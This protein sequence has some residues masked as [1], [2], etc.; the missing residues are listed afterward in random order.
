MAKHETCLLFNSTNEM[1]KVSNSIDYYINNFGGIS[2]VLGEVKFEVWYNKQLDSGKTAN[3]INET[4]KN[5]SADETNELIYNIFN[6]S[7]KVITEKNFTVT[8]EELKTNNVLVK[9]MFNNNNFAVKYDKNIKT[10]NDLIKHCLNEYLKNYLNNVNF[11]YD[12]KG[13]ATYANN[14]VS[15]SKSLKN[16]VQDLTDAYNLYKTTVNSYRDEQVNLQQLSVD[17][18]QDFINELLSNSDFRQFVRDI[19]AQIQ[20]PKQNSIWQKIL[21]AIKNFFSINNKQPYTI[22]HKAIHAVNILLNDINVK[23]IDDI[24]NDKKTTTISDIND[25]FTNVISVK[26]NTKLNADNTLTLTNSNYNLYQGQIVKIKVAENNIALSNIW[27]IS[28]I[29]NDVATLENINPENIKLYNFETQHKINNV[30]SSEIQNENNNQNNTLN[31]LDESIR[32]GVW[33]DEQ[34]TERAYNYTVKNLDKLVDDYISNAGNTIDPDAIREVYKP[35]GYTG[36]NVPAFRKAEKLLTETIFEK[37]IDKAVAEGKTSMTFLTGVPGSGKSSSLRNNNMDLSDQG[38]V[39][40]AAFNGSDKLIKYIKKV[41]DRGLKNVTVLAVHNDAITSFTNTLNR[42]IATGRFLSL[43]YFLDGAFG[44]NLNKIQDI[45]DQCSDINIIPI[46]NSGNNGGKQVTIEEA[47]N[48]DYNVTEELVYKLLNIIED[49]I[50]KGNISGEQI[51]SVGR[52]VLEIK[53]L[54]SERVQRIAKRIENKIKSNERDNQ[55][56]TGLSGLGVNSQQSAITKNILNQILDHLKKGA[57]VHFSAEM[58]EYL[59]KHNLEDLQKAIQYNEEITAIKDAAIKNGTFMKAPNGE[60]TNLNERQWLQVRTK[61]FK[62]WFGDWENDPQN[63][64][65]IVDENGE[66]KVMWHTAKRGKF[67]GKQIFRKGTNGGKSGNGIYF[68]FSR[69]KTFANIKG[70]YTYQVFLNMRNPLTR[71]FIKDHNLDDMYVQIG[72]HIIELN[73]LEKL[74]NEYGFDGTFAVGALDEV[75][76]FEPNQIKSAT[77]NN[78]NFS[79]TDDDIRAAWGRP[80]VNN[81]MSDEEKENICTLLKTIN[82]TGTTLLDNG[83]GTIINQVNDLSFFTT[84]QGEIYGFVTKDGEIYLDETVISPEHPIHEY[85]HLW[86]RMVQQQN[87]ELWKRGVELMK[88]TSMWTDIANDIHY[89]KLWE[90]QG[91]TGTELEDRIASEVHAR[92]TGEGGA[93]LLDQIAKE[94]GSEGIIAK[95]KDWIKE[96]WSTLKATFSN[97]SKKDLDKLTLKDFN[98]MTVRDFADG[99]NFENLSQQSQQSQSTSVLSNLIQPKKGV[100]LKKATAKASIANKFIGFGAP[101]SSTALY[102]QQAGEYAN[103]GDYTKDDT[104]FVSINGKVKNAIEYQLQTI[105]EAV[106]AIRSGARLL[107]DSAEYL[108][109]SSYNT[110]EK[111]LAEHLKLIGATYQTIDIDGEKVG[112]WTFSAKMQATNITIAQLADAIG[113]ENVVTDRT[114][115]TAELKNIRKTQQYANEYNVKEEHLQE[116]LDIKNAAIQNGTFMKAPNGKPSNLDERKWL[117]VRTKTFKEWFGD[118]ENDPQNASKV[119]DENG[120]PK[121]VYH[122]TNNIFYIFD[123]NKLGSNTGALS[124]KLGFFT[125]DDIDNSDRYRYNPKIPKSVIE[126]L[127]KQEMIKTIINETESGKKFYEE[128]EL[129]KNNYIQKVTEMFNSF[130]KRYPTKPGHRYDWEDYTTTFEII[131]PNLQIST[132]IL[133]PL[134]K[135]YI[136][137]LDGFFKFHDLSKLDES[138]IKESKD[139]INFIKNNLEKIKLFSEKFKNLTFTTEEQ[140]VIQDAMQSEQLMHEKKGTLMHLFLN[141][142]DPKIDDDHGHMYREES[143]SSRMLKAISQNKDGGIIKNTHD[144]LAT[145]VYYFFDPNQAKSATDNNGDFSNT[146]DDIRYHKNNNDENKTLDIIKFFK[147]SKGDIFGFVGK[148]NKIYLDITMIDSNTAIHE[149]THLWVDALKRTNSKEWDHV[150]NLMRNIKSESGKVLWDYVKKQY[151]ELKT[152]SEIAEEVLAHYSGEQGAIK[153]EKFIEKMPCTVNEKQTFFKKLKE[154]L[155]SFWK[156][157]AKMLGDIHY[158]TAQHVA[159][160]VLYDFANKINPNEI[161]KTKEEEMQKQQ[162]KQA[163]NNQSVQQNIQNIQSQSTANTT[164]QPQQPQQQEEHHYEFEMNIDDLIGNDDKQQPATTTIAN[165]DPVRQIPITISARDR[166]HETM[167][168]EQIA[169]RTRFLANVFDHVVHNLLHNDYSDAAEHFGITE[170]EANHLSDMDM[171]RKI[172]V[173]EIFNY[174]KDLMIKWKDKKIEKDPKITNKVWFNQLINILDDVNFETLKNKAL[175]TSL[176]ANQS[177]LNKYRNGKDKIVDA[178]TTTE[179]EI[180]E[181][182]VN[183]VERDND[184]QNLIDD[185]YN[186]D[187]EIVNVLQSDFEWVKSVG[188]DGLFKKANNQVKLLLRGIRIKYFVDGKSVPKKNDFGFSDYMDVKTMF[189][190]IQRLNQTAISPKQLLSRIKEKSEVNPTFEDLYDRLKPIPIKGLSGQEYKSAIKENNRKLFLLKQLYSATNNVYLKNVDVRDYLIDTDEGVIKSDSGYPTS[191]FTLNMVDDGQALLDAWKADLSDKEK[192]KKIIDFAHDE[193]VINVNGEKI[194]VG[195]NYYLKK[196]RDIYKKYIKKTGIQYIDKNGYRRDKLNQDRISILKEEIETLKEILDVLDLKLIENNCETT[197]DIWE[198]LERHDLQYLETIEPDEIGST[199]TSELS[200]CLLLDCLNDG[201]NEYDGYDYITKGFWSTKSGVKHPVYLEW[202]KFANLFG[203]LYTQEVEKSFFYNGKTFMSDIP[204]SRISDILKI[205]QCGDEEYIN[206]WINENYKRVKWYGYDPKTNT[207][208]NEFLT[209]VLINREI[210][211]IC[212]QRF[213]S[214]A[215]ETRVLGEVLYEKGEYEIKEVDKFTKQDF[216]ESFAAMYKLGYS[217]LPPLADSGNLLYIKTRANTSSG[218]YNNE[219]LYRL[220]TDLAEQEIDRIAEVYRREKEVISKNPYA[221][222]KNYDIVRNSDGT[223]K[224]Y[225]GAKFVFLEALNDCRVFATNDEDLGTIVTDGEKVDISVLSKKG[226]TQDDFK[227]LS[228]VYTSTKHHNG[229]LYYRIGNQYIY[230]SNQRRMLE[231]I[232]EDVMNRYADMYVSKIQIGENYGIRDDDGHDLYQICKD[233]RKRGYEISWEKEY[234]KDAI[235]YIKNYYLNQFYNFVSITQLTVGDLAY[236]KEMQG[237][238]MLDFAK[239]FKGVFGRTTRLAAEPNEKLRFIILKDEEFSSE[240]Y[241][242]ISTWCDELVKQGTFK[243][244]DAKTIKGSLLNITNTDGQGLISPAAL[245]DVYES[246][247]NV[248]YTIIEALRILQYD[249]F[250]HEQE[251]KIEEVES[252]TKKDVDAAK[253]V[254]LENISLFCNPIKPFLQT[255]YIKPDETGYNKESIPLQV[256]NSEFLI[257]PLTVVGGLF[258]KSPK[259]KALYRIMGDANIDRIQFESAIKVGSTGVIDVSQL[260]DENEIYDTIINAINNDMFDKEDRLK[261]YQHNKEQG[262]N[263]RI[264]DKGNVVKSIPKM[265]FG[266]QVDT[267]QNDEETTYGS[268]LKGIAMSN[269]DSSQTYTIKIGNKNLELNGDEIREIFIALNKRLNKLGYDQLTKRYGIK[270]ND[271]GDYILNDKK[272]NDAIIKDMANGVFDETNLVDGFVLNDKN[273]PVVPYNE[274]NV[275]FSIYKTLASCIKNYIFKQKVK[276]KTLIQ[277]SNFGVSKDLHCQFGI[278]VNDKK[279][280]INDNW[281]Q[282]NKRKNTELSQELGLDKYDTYLDWANVMW[283][284][285]KIYLDYID[286]YTPPFD[287]KMREA[288]TEEVKDKNGK[289]IGTHVNINKKTT[290]QVKDKNGNITTKEVPILDPRLRNFI[291]YRIPSEANCSIF[292]CRVKDFLPSLFGETVM[293]PAEFIAITGSDFDIDKI[294]TIMH[295]H[296]TTKDGRL[297]KV[298]DKSLNNVNSKDDLLN[299]ISNMNKQNIN[300]MLIDTMTAIFANPNTLQKTLFP[301]SYQTLKHRFYTLN[302]INNAKEDFE[303]IQEKYGIDFTNINDVTN[304]DIK[305]LEKINDKY[306]KKFDAC[307]LETMLDIQDNNMCGKQN[308]GIYAVGSKLHNVLMSINTKIERLGTIQ[309]A[310]HENDE[311]YNTTTFKHMYDREGRLITNNIKEFQASSVDNGKDPILYML[312]QNPTTAGMTNIMLLAG[313]TIDDIVFFFNQP[314][315]IELTKTI[316]NNLTP[317]KSFIGLNHVVLGIT[318]VVKNNTDNQ[319]SVDYVVNNIITDNS[320]STLYTDKMY[321]SVLQDKN[322][323]EERFVLF[324]TF[325]NI[326]KITDE[327]RKISPYI[328]SDNTKSALPTNIVKTVKYLVQMDHIRDNEIEIEGF[329]AGNIAD[330][331]DNSSAGFIQSYLQDGIKT[332]FESLIKTLQP[333]IYELYLCLKQLTLGTDPGLT[334]LSAIK[335][336]QKEIIKYEYRNYNWFRHN[337]DITNGTF[338]L[339]FSK[340]KKSPDYK[341]YFEKNSFLR[342]LSVNKNNIEL[343]TVLTADKSVLRERMINDWED[344]LYYVNPKDSKDQTIPNLALELFVYC[345]HKSGFQTTSKSDFVQYIPT[346]IK[347]MLPGYLEY[348]ENH[349][350]KSIT[351]QN[352]D[353]FLDQYVLLCKDAIIPKIKLNK[354]NAKFDDYGNF[355][356]TDENIKYKPKYLKYG[357]YIYKRND[358]TDWYNRMKQQSLIYNSDLDIELLESNDKDNNNKELY[359]TIRYGGTFKFN[360]T[361]IS[362]GKEKVNNMNLC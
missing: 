263:I 129:E 291:G 43:Q 271:N 34:L 62:E 185:L 210:P 216:E 142:R 136:T 301:S 158:D 361:D 237:N 33:T 321:E 320:K 163:Q 29:T 332:P 140:S 14:D 275:E 334:P 188:Q 11:N 303:E 126:D 57:K 73:N 290:I 125:C 166:L 341:D 306:S 100:D 81:K 32:T 241:S 333:Q 219:N 141:I 350:G 215:K 21:N 199:L 255:N 208:K 84:P 269:L 246:M 90:Q 264:F 296:K 86:D 192:V 293:L 358:N 360:S 288:L 272:V 262:S 201:L 316:Q 351:E 119:I 85:T 203:S 55:G 61:A 162:E 218:H 299:A 24:Q 154:V 195:R 359:K 200:N 222:I 302:I 124:A 83:E 168:S 89:G 120:E 170:D 204:P 336:L 224:T 38:I 260:Q 286:I 30:V 266:I 112:Q 244:S 247:G 198:R 28:N 279:I 362:D 238:T 347:E 25:I 36:K 184:E 97:W 220:F 2:K 221:K 335:S 338:A 96:F 281:F 4:I 77:D 278:V 155:E 177:Q 267:T 212:L 283:K 52:D 167:T 285:G 123:K 310:T 115:A 145:N 46:D 105:D 213:R 20:K 3:E 108:D 130:R 196:L 47:I 165:I 317:G 121:V 186:A 348:T 150:V 209:R 56:E 174:I 117:Q 72:G 153:L 287:E 258:S 342:N 70:S 106:K 134:I 79:L 102:Q 138:A 160:K 326:F 236:F 9:T 164:Q 37:M 71:D 307:T 109:K 240:F 259:L 355:K 128:Y 172:G 242:E 99:V 107:T 274:P 182:P 190:E 93:K 139:I 252:I 250:S 169:Y 328:R 253:Q 211:D 5:L 80:S 295:E 191:V 8:L 268:Q 75:T 337:R 176:I 324:K 197:E 65:K 110:G 175:A 297:V 344:M 284:S 239:R 354:K 207:F 15:T 161:Q 114:I 225:G 58:K 95:L 357:K 27:R 122:G 1:Q 88:K 340:L 251:S 249:S 245:A 78:G 322:T 217:P 173:D 51:T 325:Y 311:L 257:L 356:I 144:P 270:Q 205:L 223:I 92:F 346:K 10:E 68:A 289:V 330:E 319:E 292:T 256:K 229:G 91:I 261:I 49:E 323:T 104:V 352:I 294:F 202:V 18:V 349:Y 42:G 60:T 143:Y 313:Y 67:E 171:I 19:D 157:I 248:S 137:E 147:T 149:Y 48:W 113:N 17:N 193:L 304:A 280:I 282:A 133:D 228:E 64:S 54:T 159:D 22:E 254:I 331:N 329:N 44:E 12:K 179:N 40:D 132:R 94:K 98:H 187:E 276:G 6:K 53:E 312:Q 265:L 156:Q 39:Y 131:Y 235:E 315:I 226:V 232:V 116:M 314:A 214:I 45:I 227:P 318:E 146:E 16:A 194:K 327:L 74:V 118:W 178:N 181:E 343:Q 13:I 59:K 230:F 152:D 31:E 308:I 148:D 82:R 233:I 103:V 305:I 50:N 231:F 273:K 135:Y 183:I 63:A 111:L 66:P 127:V 7:P 309:I 243:E 277:A 345:F 298:S 300:N 234:K 26:G 206:Q 35:L 76:V 151:P 23:A 101:N 353:D 180:E 339:Y 41:Q 69:Y 189:C 87:P